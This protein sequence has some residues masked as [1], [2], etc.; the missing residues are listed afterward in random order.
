M[1]YDF[2]EA[3]RSAAQIGVTT[4]NK[5]HLQ[6]CLAAIA[7]RRD[8]STCHLDGQNLKVAFLDGQ[9]FVMDGSAR[10]AVHNRP[11]RIFVRACPS[12]PFYNVIE[13]AKKSVTDNVSI[14]TVYYLRQ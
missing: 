6:G 10:R 13:T 7:S 14:T 1:L 4:R 11:C 8:P 9:L 2:S 5:H 12:M 3:H